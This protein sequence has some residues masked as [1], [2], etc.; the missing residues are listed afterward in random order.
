MTELTTPAGEDFIYASDTTGPLSRKLKIDTLVGQ[1]PIS[2]STG[3]GATAKIIIPGLAGSPDIAG[4]AGAGFSEEWDTTSTGLTWNSTPATEDSDTT[5]KSHINIGIA[6]NSTEY[7]GTR[8]WSPT[9]A[10]DVRAK[11]SGMQ[12]SSTTAVSTTAGLI[13]CNSDN[14]LR[15]LITVN[16]LQSTGVW[17][18][19]SY[20]YAS[21]SYTQRSGT[22]ASHGPPLYL[23]ITRDGSNN[24]YCWYSLSGMTNS[25]LILN[26]T[27]LTLTVAK[28]GLRL[29]NTTGANTIYAIYDWLRAD[30]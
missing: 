27:A 3:T 6:S 17:D 9:E 10:F 8:S 1:E 23:R 22:I 19:K 7:I 18:I 5:V 14:S 29:V 4:A 21:S 25:W 26:A 11:F 2:A 24:T 28:V 15:I 20:T 16:L 12:S 13:V 30:V